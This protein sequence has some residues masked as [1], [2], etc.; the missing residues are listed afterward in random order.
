M[1]RI[2]GFRHLIWRGAPKSGVIAA[3]ALLSA[4]L[5]VGTATVASGADA[6]GGPPRGGPPPGAP[7][8]TRLE[9][10]SPDLLAVALVQGDRMIIHLSRL[11]DN[12]PLRD[13][14]VMVVLRGTAHPTV[15][16]ADGSY[17]LTA[18]DLALPGS[19]AVDFLVVQSQ[20]HENLHAVLQAG[21]LAAAPEEKSNSRQ[22]WWW[23]LNFGVCIGFLVLFSRRKKSAQS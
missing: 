12:A 20:L 8:P 5:G 21:S 18:K 6:G 16:E 14:E 2:M 13:A 15:A 9:A 3:I 4:A 17:T 23:A 1:F 10:R 22:L 7:P 19:A 11:L